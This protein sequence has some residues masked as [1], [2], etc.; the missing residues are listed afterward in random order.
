MGYQIILHLDPCI[1]KPVSK[2]CH[3]AI[4][5]VYKHSWLKAATVFL[6]RKDSS[7]RWPFC[8]IPSPPKH[9]QKPGAYLHEVTPRGELTPAPG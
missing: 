3:L 9:S 7:F 5:S 6:G 2:L 8:D 1:I 4:P